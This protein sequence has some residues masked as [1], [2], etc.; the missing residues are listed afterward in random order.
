MKKFSFGLFGLAMLLGN[1]LGSM[2]GVAIALCVWMIVD[3][4]IEEVQKH[5]KNKTGKKEVK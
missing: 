4:L 2:L 3:G 5:K 1:Q